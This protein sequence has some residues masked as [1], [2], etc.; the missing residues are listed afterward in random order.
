MEDSSAFQGK[1]SR[2]QHQF[3]QYPERRQMAGRIGSF[4]SK[5][6]LST[7]VVLSSLKS[8]QFPLSKWPKFSLFSNAGCRKWEEKM[9]SKSTF[10]IE[11]RNPSEFLGNS[12]DFLSGNR[13]FGFFLK[14][15]F[16][17]LSSS[18]N[19]GGAGDKKR[20]KKKKK[21]MKMK[22]KK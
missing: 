17:F 7:V 3:P 9:A 10:S 13:K 5:I 14:G 8:G 2:Q 20:K 19:N 1:I 6:P 12:Q 15:F 18:C 22:M 4:F 16:F 21:K 11:K